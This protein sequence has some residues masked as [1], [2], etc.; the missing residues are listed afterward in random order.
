MSNQ[1]INKKDENATQKFYNRV[2]D[3]EIPQIPQ[4]NM[5]VALK[6]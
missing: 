6:Q 2:T 3:K 5:M 1:P 4:Q